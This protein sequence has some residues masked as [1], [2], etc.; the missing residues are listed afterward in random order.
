MKKLLPLVIASTIFLGAMSAEAKTF[1]V[2]SDK[3]S[4]NE[5]AFISKATIVKFKGTT[6]NV[7]GKIELPKGDLSEATGEIK[8]DLSSLDTGI[9]ARNDHM[10]GTLETNKY[11]WAVFKI[12]S[13]KSP[14]K[15]PKGP[16]PFTAILIGDI[17]LHGV[18]KPLSLPIELSYLPETDKKYRPG[19]WV[20]ATAEFK[21]NLKDHQISLP[22]GV[23]GMKVAETVA[24]ELDAML[25]A[26]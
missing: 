6:S 18:S 20:H 13:I 19:E 11:Q 14:V 24:I 26:E 1:K 2:S 16:E 3:H 10:R 15:E 23:L 7:V 8:V 22:E 5:V 9:E 25:K 12:K 4:P 17:S 21:I